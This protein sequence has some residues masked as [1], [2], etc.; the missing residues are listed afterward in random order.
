M[1]KRG[2]RF[3]L[4]LAKMRSFCSKG[5][6]LFGGCKWT[7]ANFVYEKYL[8]RMWV[9]I[10]LG[11]DLDYFD[12]VYGF[13]IGIQGESGA[14][15]SRWSFQPLSVLCFSFANRRNVYQ[16]SEAVSCVNPDSNKYTTKL[17]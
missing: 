7:K 16:H 13:L 9:D 15:D 6:K 17:P 12:E 11:D 10:N 5:R 4:Y 2:D 3:L 1:K 8:A 14:I